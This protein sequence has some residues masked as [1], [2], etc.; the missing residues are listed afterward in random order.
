MR[1]FLIL[2]IMLAVE[3]G[4]N[5]CWEKERFALLQIKDSINFPNG[6]SLPSWEEDDYLDCCQWERVTCNSTTHRVIKLSL[7]TSRDWRRD[8]YWYLN[9][10]ILLPFESLRS[11]DLSDNQ[12]YGFVGNEG[13]G[14]LSNLSNLKELDL[15]WNYLENSI[16]LSLNK[17]S[18]LKILNLAGNIL[19]GSISINGKF[20]IR[21]TVQFSQSENQKSEHNLSFF[22]E[23][24]FGH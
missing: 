6:T 15:H 5:G 21:T 10:S 1:L 8:D 2:V 14:I 24:C 12:L 19:N 7:N 3:N 22:P 23:K 17:L 16:L 13:I 9:A 18:N 20:K 11:L 4:C